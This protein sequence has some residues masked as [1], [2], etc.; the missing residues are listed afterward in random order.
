M[1]DIVTID[2]S[3]RGSSHLIP[4]NTAI[5]AYDVAELEFQFATGPCAVTR[6]IDGV[7]FVAWPAWD[8][9]DNQLSSLTTPGIYYTTGNGVLKFSADVVVRP[10]EG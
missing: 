10:M 8:N 7:N 2:S 3:T 5:A 6:S 9:S 1:P 4:A